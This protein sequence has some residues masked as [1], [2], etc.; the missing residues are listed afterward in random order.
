[1]G[2]KKTK[3]QIKTKGF[4]QPSHNF[5]CMSKFCRRTKTA[6]ISLH[7]NRKGCGLDWQY[8]WDSEQI[9]NLTNVFEFL[10]VS[11]QIDKTSLESFSIITQQPLDILA[12]YFSIF[13][14]FLNANYEYQIIFWGY[15]ANFA[16][17]GLATSRVIQKS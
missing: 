14:S 6:A 17:K 15:Y 1:M 12:H 11:P 3:I 4:T 5:F 2:R 9:S 7:L 8:R 10:L 16:R 13:Y